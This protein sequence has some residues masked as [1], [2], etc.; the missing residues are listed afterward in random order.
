MHPS[1]S[2]D[3]LEKIPAPF[4]DRAQAALS[5]SWS[6]IIAL[7]SNLRDMPNTSLPLLLPV[8]FAILAPAHIDATVLHLELV[9]AEAEAEASKALIMKDRIAGILPAVHALAAL[10]DQ[11]HVPLGSFD[12]LWPR[13]WA[14]AEFSA[15]FYAVTATDEREEE[16]SELYTRFTQVFSSMRR[17]AVFVSKYER[18]ICHTAGFYTFVGAAWSCMVRTSA[19][20]GVTAVSIILSLESEIFME[21]LDGRRDEKVQD[22]LVGAGGTWDD[23]A[24]L[25]IR[26]AELAVPYAEFDVTVDDISMCSGLVVLLRDA[27]DNRPQLRAALAKHGIIKALVVACRAFIHSSS[28]IRALA[29]P[30]QFIAEQ[31]FKLL[32]GHLTT[33]R[34]NERV[35]EAL[36]AGLLHVIVAHAPHFRSVDKPISMELFLILQQLLP[37]CTV[38]HSV[39]VQLR[40]SLDELGPVPSSQFST[41]ATLS[42]TWD[43][44]VELVNERLEVM[45]LYEAG[46]L[47]KLRACDNLKCAALRE[48]GQ[49]QRCSGCQSAYYCSIEC[50]KADYTSGQHRKFCAKLRSRRED[51]AAELGPEDQDPAFLR[52]LVNYHYDK[53]KEQIALGLV[54]V[55]SLS[56]SVRPYTIF[57]FTR[58]ECDISIAASLDEEISNAIELDIVRRERGGAGAAGRMDMHVVGIQTGRHVHMSGKTRWIAMPLR[59]ATAEMND[60]LRELARRVAVPGFQPGGA[61]DTAVYRGEVQEILERFKLVAQTH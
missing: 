35:I 61:I 10:V 7:N 60:A 14:W 37:E 59:S 53:K 46:E 32:L 57:D 8:L 4:K 58:G 30:F 36:R 17:K 44:F 5:G 41:D 21:N 25:L 20:K 34:S 33:A 22:L 26:H 24:V 54:G 31:F 51:L 56:P 29:M 55:M 45:D 3:H 49:I 50:Q 15:Q 16:R 9:E 42:E 2:L 1:L 39:L 12:D 19:I 28:S 47:T 23:F 40:I 52:A 43:S 6:D 13:V 11:H 18:L 38:F 27:I 48:Y